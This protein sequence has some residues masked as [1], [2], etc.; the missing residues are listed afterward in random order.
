MQ[1]KSMAWLVP[2]LVLVLAACTGGGGNNEPESAAAPQP[3][4]SVAAS[5]PAA[6]NP[7]AS[8]A[9]GSGELLVWADN[10]ANTAKAIKP[11]CEAGPPTTGSPAK[12]R[13]STDG[14]R[15]EGRAPQGQSVREC[16]GHLR[17]AARPDRPVRPGWRPRAD[18]PGRQRVEV[19]RGCRRRRHRKRQRVRRPMGSGEHRAAHQ[20]EPGAQLPGDPRR[21][22]RQRQAAHRR[23][24]G[25]EGPR[26]RD[27]DRR[28]GRCLPLVPA[29]HR[30]RWVC[31]RSEP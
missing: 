9:A 15:V 22:G 19:R 28:E 25:H 1:R 26:H 13:T 4:T 11:L 18:R 23:R 3:A 5:Q 10:S 7:A 8:V 29:V 14:R 27:A 6:S 12:S 31:I 2:G 21:G 30:G 17:R 20:Q 16:A 24:Q